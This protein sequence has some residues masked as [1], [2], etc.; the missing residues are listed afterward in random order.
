MSNELE[1]WKF[2]LGEWES[3]PETHV[4]NE[5]GAVN[6]AKIDHKPSDQFI[7]MVNEVF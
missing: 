7:F 2:L 1:K 6:H 3:D 5:N 4:G